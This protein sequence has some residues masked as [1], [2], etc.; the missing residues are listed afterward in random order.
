MLYRPIIFIAILL[1]G[2]DATAQTNTFPASG[3]VGIGTTNPVQ[4]LDIANGSM[5]IETSGFP[6]LLG[7]TDGSGSALVQSSCGS[8]WSNDAVGGETILRSAANKPLILQSG[9][10]RSHIYLDSSGN[11][12]IGTATPQYKLNVVGGD[13][14]QSATGDTPVQMWFQAGG[15]A[16]P[17]RFIFPSS[18]NSAQLGAGANNFGIFN[19][20]AGDY[21]L[22]LRTDGSLKLGMGAGVVIRNSGIAFSDGTNQTTAWNGVLCGGDYAESVSVS[23][24][25][26]AYE[27]GDVIV[28]D[29]ANSEH[30]LKSSTP[31]STVVA[32]I[33]S[34]KPGAIGRRTKN[35]DKANLEIPM[36]MVGIVPTKVNAENGPIK[37]GDLLVTS[38]TPGYAMKGTDR[39]QMLGAVVGKAMETLASGQGVID[40]L[41]TLQ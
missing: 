38:S 17:W 20:T 29:T 4:K 28:M 10:G 7:N 40:V 31:Y 11:V 8:C 5:T 15:V 18:V 32:G 30:F 9:T 21:L 3:N 19:Q 1:V 22:L 37:I 39:T 13:I 23:G 25:R 27:P 14:G 34:T 6:L 26:T 35:P 24:Y 36:A 41:V 2:A 33:Y 12:G 16:Q